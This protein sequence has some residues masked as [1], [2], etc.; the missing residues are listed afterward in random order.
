MCLIVKEGLKISLNLSSYSDFILT[1]IDQ[2][3]IKPKIINGQ[4]LRIDPIFIYWY[5]VNF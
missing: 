1:Q 4:N 2:M 5:G 3:T